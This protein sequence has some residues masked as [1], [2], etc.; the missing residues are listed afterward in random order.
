MTYSNR[1]VRIFR[2]SGCR[3]LFSGFCF[4]LSGA[5]SAS[6]WILMLNF[7]RPTREKSY[8]RGSKNIPWK[9]WVRVD[10]GG[11]PGRNLR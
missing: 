3:P 8:L 6:S 2:S 11:S 5:N 10:G 4:Q 9:S 1:L 7:M